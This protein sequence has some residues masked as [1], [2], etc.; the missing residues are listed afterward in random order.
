MGVNDAS[1]EASDT[2]ATAA[3]HG[4]IG[5]G[6]G[7]GGARDNTAGSGRGANGIIIIR[8]PE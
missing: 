7:G 5:T 6:S 3:K 8:Y 4:T 1:S 2:S